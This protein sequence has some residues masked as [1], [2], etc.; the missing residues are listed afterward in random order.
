MFDELLSELIRLPSDDEGQ[1]IANQ[2][3]LMLLSD[4]CHL[5]VIAISLSGEAVGSFEQSFCFWMCKPA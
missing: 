2:Y 4:Q 1:H 3:S 5:M